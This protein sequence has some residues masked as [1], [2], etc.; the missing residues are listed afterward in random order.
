MGVE[1]WRFHARPPH[2]AF[3]FWEVVTCLN[4]GPVDLDLCIPSLEGSLGHSSCLVE[5]VSCL[6]HVLPKD[7]ACYGAQVAVGLLSW[8]FFEGVAPGIAPIASISP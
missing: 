6:G 7:Q 8:A 5:A 3:S 4:Q 1:G 2:N